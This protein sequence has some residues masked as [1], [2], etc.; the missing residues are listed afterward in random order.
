VHLLF[1]YHFAP[2]GCGMLQSACL[3]V[4][5]SAQKPHDQTSRNFLHTLLLTVA[6]SFSDHN[7]IRYVLPVLWMTSCFKNGGNRPKSKTTR[8]HGTF[9]RVRQVAA[10]GAKS[11]VSNC[12]WFI[13]LAAS[14]AES[15]M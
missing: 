12:I 10:P 8:M 13:T 5:L 4:C 7:A 11:A 6:R 15:I 3:Y 1:I 9:R 14:I 2:M